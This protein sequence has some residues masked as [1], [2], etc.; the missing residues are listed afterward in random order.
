MLAF[1]FK[2]LLMNLALPSL[3]TLTLIALLLLVVVVLLLLLLL[4]YINMYMR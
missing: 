3:I 1:Y 4:L 2:C